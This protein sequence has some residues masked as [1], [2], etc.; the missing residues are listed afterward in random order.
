M[1]DT[2]VVMAAKQPTKALEIILWPLQ[3]IIGAYVMSPFYIPL[4]EGGGGNASIAATAGSKIAVILYGFI[5]LTA[6]L[7]GVI[8]LFLNNY[9]GDRA[10]QTAA[11]IMFFIFLYFTLLR[12]LIFGPTNLL[13]ATYLIDTAVAGVVYLRLRWEGS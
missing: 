12:I 1:K 6:G 2:L 3:A 4:A 10:R 13:W 11:F 5:I 9:I 8:G 7:A